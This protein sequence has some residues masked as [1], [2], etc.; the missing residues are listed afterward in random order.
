ML[1][2]DDPAQ[3]TFGRLM[4]NAHL[5]NS[6]VCSF[7][8][9]TAGLEYLFNKYVVGGSG[10]QTILLLD[11]NM[12]EFSAWDFLYAFEQFPP[13]V[14]SLIRIFILSGNLTNNDRQLADS[15][16]YVLDCYEKPISAEMLL[17]IID[18]CRTD[19][20]YHL[21][22]FNEDRLPACLLN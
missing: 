7:D 18:K 15:C 12:P 14:K 19:A 4:I 22:L 11:I 5:D 17:S 16:E 8:K 6:L 20:Q 3:N 13:R 2:D 1:I 21:N 9:P 10:K